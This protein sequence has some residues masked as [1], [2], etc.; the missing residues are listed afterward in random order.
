MADHTLATKILLR[1]DTYARW[2]NSELIL[3]PGEV[4]VAIFSRLST[5]N[6]TDD[7][8]DNTP[9]AVG[10]KVGDG[11]SYFYELPWVQ[12]PAA[13]VYN[14]AKQPTP[15]NAT[16]IPGIDSYIGSYL[17]SHGISGGGGSGSGGGSAVTYRLYYDSNSQKYILQYY[18][19]TLQD[20]ENTSSEV[21]LSAIY[22]RINTIERW[23][24]GAKTGL[25]NIEVPIAEYVYEEVLTYLNRLDY[26]D[27]AVSHQFITSV[28]QTDGQITVTR[29]SIS[30]ADIESGVLNTAHGGT[31]L[32]Y[33]ADDEVL[34]GSITGEIT[35][36]HFTNVIDNESLNA[37]VTAGAVQNYVNQKTAGLTGAMHF[38]G[39]SSVTIDSNNNR[40]D[41]QIVGYNFRNAQPGDVILTGNAQEYVWTGS[42]WRL[43]GDEGSYAIKG[44]IVNA[45]IS[46]NANISQSK[47]S[48]LSDTFDTKVDKVE[49]KT[50]TSNDYSD[51]DKEKLDLI[52]SG[53]QVNTIEHIFVNENEVN[54][55]TVN[56]FDK[57]INLTIP[58]LSSEDLEKINS[59]SMNAQENTIEHIFVNGTEINPSTINNNPKSIG[60]N[61][62]P[63]TQEEKDKL[64]DIE[65][66]A[67][68]NKIETITI[69]GTEYTPD[70]NKSVN[71]TIDQA[72]LNL[73]VLTGAQVPSKT[74]GQ[75]EDVDITNTK[76]LSLARIAKTGDVSDLLQEADEYIVLYCGTSTEV[77]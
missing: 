56:G 2:M 71:I 27:S 53:A 57:S 28:S 40:V 70:N 20:W 42:I 10:L 45:D 15:P 31:G 34:I 58:E 37:L 17:S 6:N 77:I 3:L 16:D 38:I 47:I 5:L 30:A 9:P 52:E 51:T 19:E 33:V 14:W 4:A 61:F 48:G 8:P 69:N 68:V 46:E 63:F 62:V 24:N 26:N 44:S 54:A 23:A 43:L 74:Q 49:G 65:S 11:E 55:T 36:M 64:H 7:I 60:I 32:S 12:A 41:P 66:G 75:V 22:N 67:E 39:E 35:T 21:N 50:L 76:K 59:M 72:A 13:D 73:D 29:S 1:Y 18:D 25:G